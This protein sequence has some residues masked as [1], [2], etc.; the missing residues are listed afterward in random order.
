MRKLLLFTFTLAILSMLSLN[1]FA[2]W[3]K[4]VTVSNDTELIKAMD[5]PSV[6]RI[7]LNPGSY[8]SMG[9]EIYA[10]EGSNT[11]IAKDEGSS[12]SDCLYSITTSDRCYPANGQLLAGTSGTGCP[13]ANSGTWVQVSGPSV[14][15][16]ISPSSYLSPVQVFAPGKYVFRYEWGAPFNRFVEGDFV[17]YTLGVELETEPEVCGFE[18]TIDVELTYNEVAPAGLIGE[19]S[20]VGPFGAATPTITGDVEGPFDVTVYECGLYTFTYT[21][22]NGPCLAAS[23][24]SIYFFDTPVVT[25][26]ED[27]EICGLEYVFEAPEVD[28]DC[29]EH[30]NYAEFW[31]LV[32][33]PGTATFTFDKQTGLTTVNV[34]VCGTYTFSYTAFNGFED[35]TGVDY[36]TI[37]FYDTPVLT[38]QEDDEICGLVYEPLVAGAVVAC[39]H[40][41]YDEYWALVDGPGTATFTAT[42]VEVSVCGTYIF[43]FTAYNG[44]DGCTVSGTVTIHFYE[45][46]EEIYLSGTDELCLDDQAF[47]DFGYY[48]PCINEDGFSELLVLVEGPADVTIDANYDYGTATVTFTECGIYTFSYTVTNYPCDPV[49]AFHVVKVYEL[50]VV[51]IP[52][53]D[54]VCEDA[55]GKYFATLVAN[56]SASCF[57]GEI[58]GKWTKTSGPGLVAFDDE[59]AFT[60]GVQVSECGIYEFAFTA[61]LGPCGAV[62]ETVTVNFFDT[63]DVFVYGDAEVCGREV[64]LTAFGYAYCIEEGIITGDWTWVGPVGAPTP[65]FV[66]LGTVTPTYDILVGQCGVYTFT[67]TV[68]NNECVNSASFTV[69]FY[70][71]PE[72]LID[73]PDPAE[74]CKIADFSVTD[75]S[76]CLITGGVVSYSWWITPNTAGVFVDGVYTGENVSVEWM[77]LGEVTIWVAAFI[78]DLPVQECYGIAS[79]TLTVEAP[80]FAGQVKYWN[81]FETYM[82]SPFP[83]KDYATYPHDYF[84]VTLGWA[85][86]QMVIDSL[87][88]VKVENVIKEV[89]TGDDENPTWDL[90]ELS[91]YFEFD[92]GSIF[93]DT[94][95]YIEAFGC[96]GFFLKIWDGGLHYYDWE[97]GY[98]L[99]PPQAARHLGNNYTYNYWG[100]VNATDALGIQRMAATINVANP[101]Y[102]WN[103]I[104]QHT[105]S[106]RYGYYSHSAADV[107]SS[108]PYTNGGITALD[109]LT[110]NYRAV[111]LIDVFPNSQSGIQYSPNFRVTGRMVD[112]LPQMTWN[113]PFNYPNVDDVPFYHSNQSYLYFHPAQMHQYTSVPIALSDKNFI[114]I[115]YLALGDVNSSYVPPVPGFKAEVQNELAYVGEQIV[116]KGEVI[117]VPIRINR[118]AEVAALSM[119]LSYNTSLVEVLG[120]NYGSDYSMI[121]AENGIINIGWYGDPSIYAFGDAIVMIKVRVLADI[122]ANA[123]PFEFAADP[124]IADNTMNIVKAGFETIA[125]NAVDAGLF[126]TNYPNPFRTT[127]MISYSTP[128]DGT[129]TLVVYNKLG[130]VVETLVSASQTAGT[131][132]V[133]FGRADLTPGVYFYKVVVEGQGE[134][135]SVTNSMILMQ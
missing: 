86:E 11:V 128:V 23:S 1:T 114:N 97:G 28:L 66:D 36:V 31:S 102:S 76:D 79:F 131:Y 77:E 90:T 126:A 48:I 135:H 110:A 38:I 32:D 88:T 43:S 92:L 41:D 75:L 127:T 49:T 73:G 78:P 122:T 19:W 14:A 53:V 69:T 26:Q 13:A 83:T 125:L 59:D 27:D 34:S 105:W 18:A 62:T 40:P 7:A 24:V 3:G 8:L 112:M 98:G 5:D 51:V 117:E 130:Q 50:P 134:T 115:Y 71:A 21:V 118:S 89:F 42:G 132:V 99:N 12:R 17:W 6:Q 84:Y 85:G 58:T 91:S 80:I 57:E 25:V 39:E 45:E 103:W 54:D 68:S 95:T 67:Y 116:R 94:W 46:T 29:L 129:V 16:I 10:F 52:D 74:F 44:F 47:L 111:G 2:Q 133:E 124:E 56:V 55:D 108:N 121:D 9:E 106:P 81:Q 109:A 4:T 120:V 65:T 70:D 35:C 101:P 64:E 33:G 107:N 60:T 100:G 93:T 113:Q 96:E 61:Y 22:S 87:T 82:P 123:R 37:K 20:F 30:E 63:P 104:G 72:P 15:N 119:S